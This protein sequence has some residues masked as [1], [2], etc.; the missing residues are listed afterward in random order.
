M[1]PQLCNL[2]MLNLNLKFMTLD[3]VWGSHAVYYIYFMLVCRS[4]NLRLKFCFLNPHFIFGSSISVSSVCDGVF[5]DWGENKADSTRRFKAFDHQNLS[6]YYLTVISGLTFFFFYILANSVRNLWVVRS[7]FRQ[8]KKNRSI[9]NIDIEV[10][11]VKQV[12]P[13]R[14]MQ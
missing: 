13:N 5:R 3:Y 8:W 1:R 9:I 4:W 7:L 10:T 11:V 12:W 6:D 2:N 14:S